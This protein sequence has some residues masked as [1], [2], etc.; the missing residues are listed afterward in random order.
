MSC[1][2]LP[3]GVLLAGVGDARPPPPPPPPPLPPARDLPG[4]GMSVGKREGVAAPVILAA[5]RAFNVP[6]PNRSCDILDARVRV[7]L[8]VERVAR[9]EPDVPVVVVLVL[10]LPAGPVPLEL[11]VALPSL[12]V[13]SR[14]TSL[15][16]PPRGM[17]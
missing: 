12:V 10:E 11:V 15:T 3:P 16:A 14:G 17:R 2:P 8:V 13:R 7:V 9:P 6:L 5:A 1:D 4:A